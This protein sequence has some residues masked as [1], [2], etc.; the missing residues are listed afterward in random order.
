MRVREQ[1]IKFTIKYDA[2][3]AGGACSGHGVQDNTGLWKSED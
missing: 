2:T 3:D 1:W